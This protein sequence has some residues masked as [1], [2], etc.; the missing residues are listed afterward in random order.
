M[1]NPSQPPPT[2]TPEA[3]TQAPLIFAAPKTENPMIIFSGLHRAVRV[4]AAHA[5]PWGEPVD[6]IREAVE[7]CN[8]LGIEIDLHFRDDLIA[9][10]PG[11]CHIRLA[12]AFESRAAARA[13]PVTRSAR[14]ARP[15]ASAMHLDEP[16]YAPRT[17]IVLSNG[18]RQSDNT[19]AAIAIL[20][21]VL[22]DYPLNRTFEMFGGFVERD[23]RNLRGEWLEGLENAVSFFGNFLNLSHVFRIVSND[24]VVVDRLA[25]AIAA[26]RARPDYLRQPPPYDPAKLVIERKHIRRGHSE[27]VLTYGGQRIGQFPDAINNA[28]SAGFA[29][30]D[31]R[32]WHMFAKRQL[33]RSHLEKFDRT[34]RH[35]TQ[36]TGDA[37]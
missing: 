29:G 5:R 15:V 24:P 21:D 19:E 12:E 7:H 6:V 33:E 37:Q 28:D 13:K 18:H 10:R 17:T 20:L 34:N 26:N 31:D 16:E 9:V 14:T 27:V 8:A 35:F 1:A 11:D 25:Q 36:S 23:A 32:Y 3:A 4:F 30:A 2:V 22:S